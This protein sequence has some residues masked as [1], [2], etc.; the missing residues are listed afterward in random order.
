MTKYGLYK[1]FL[2]KAA[3]NVMSHAHTVPVCDSVFTEG[4]TEGVC[5]HSLKDSHQ[6]FNINSWGHILETS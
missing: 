3:L 4:R 6:F 2:T 1:Q 5:E